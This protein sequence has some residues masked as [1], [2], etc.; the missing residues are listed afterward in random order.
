[1]TLVAELSN[2]VLNSQGDSQLNFHVTDP[3]TGQYVMLS[4]QDSRINV[5][6]EL[7]NY[8]EAHPAL[9]YKIN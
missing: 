4:R 5:T 2:L 3:E 7:I 9:T 8:I 1:M 6:A